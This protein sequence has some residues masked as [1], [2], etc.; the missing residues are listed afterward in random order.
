MNP[1]CINR[2]ALNNWAL[3]SR[4]QVFFSYQ[5]L[6]CWRNQ[7]LL[8]DFTSMKNF[9]FNQNTISGERKREC[10]TYLRMTAPFLPLTLQIA[11]RI[12]WGKATVVLH[13]LPGEQYREVLKGEQQLLAIKCIVSIVG[14]TGAS[15][16]ESIIMR[17]EEQTLDTET[18][19]I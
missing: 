1:V 15:V 7:P 11:H 3:S 5:R 18:K 8:F 17:Q 4:C 16:V 6:Q 19:A 14:F 9:K 10:K 12:G 13:L 2:R